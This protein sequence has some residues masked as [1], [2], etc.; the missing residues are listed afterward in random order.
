MIDLES[1][2]GVDQSRIASELSGDETVIINLETGVY[3]SL[4]GVSAIVWELVRANQDIMEM[5]HAIAVHFAAPPDRVRSDLDS[6]LRMLEAENF[7][8]QS[9]LPAAAEVDLQSM[10]GSGAYAAMTLE[11]FDD[12]EE[13]LA[14]DPPT[15]GAL[16]NLMRRPY[17]EDGG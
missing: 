14:L 7:L 11:R 5:T 10:F 17:S 6:F 8:I 16:D 15:P 4:V 2:I 9:D 1:R 13:L 3:Y 12:M